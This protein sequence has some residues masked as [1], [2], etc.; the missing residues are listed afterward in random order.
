[1]HI[2]HDVTINAFHILNNGDARKLR[3]PL[4]SDILKYL[5]ELILLFVQLLVLIDKFVINPFGISANNLKLPININVL[6]K[7]HGTNKTILLRT[8]GIVAKGAGYCLFLGFLILEFKDYCV[9]AEL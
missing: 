8:I 9:A 6:H 4:I 1:L 3:L 7:A 5:Q 2:F